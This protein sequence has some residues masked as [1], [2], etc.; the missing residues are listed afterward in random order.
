VQLL[1]EKD[2]IRSTPEDNSVP[3]TTFYMLSCGTVLWV[4]KD[5]NTF[6]VTGQDVQNT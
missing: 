3:N 6:Q 4:C 2:T 1:T 5:I